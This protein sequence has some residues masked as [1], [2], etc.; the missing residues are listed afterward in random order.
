MHLLRVKKIQQS[1]IFLF[2]DNFIANISLYSLSWPNWILD[3]ISPLKSFFKHYF[4]GETNKKKFGLLDFFLPAIN[5]TVF[6]NVHDKNVLKYQWTMA[7]YFCHMSPFICRPSSPWVT[8][9]D[10][11]PDLEEWRLNGCQDSMLAT[12]AASLETDKLSPA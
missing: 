12:V 7:I 3:A 4:N 1:K 8:C 2:V 6:I 11:D 5:A 9:S 10:K